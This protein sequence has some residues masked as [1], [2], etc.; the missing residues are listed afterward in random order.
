M[1]KHTKDY[2]LVRY[3]VRITEQEHEIDFDEAREAH[4]FIG[5][6]KRLCSHCEILKRVVFDNL[7][8]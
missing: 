4:N 3:R 7:L 5:S 2:F 6:I 1:K 8:A